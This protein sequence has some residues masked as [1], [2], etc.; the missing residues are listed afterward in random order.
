MFAV[1]GGRAKEYPAEYEPKDIIVWNEDKAECQSY[2]V[3]EFSERFEADSIC[4]MPIDSNGERRVWRWSDREKILQAAS[5]GEFVLK[6]SNGNYS[7]QLKDRIKEGRKPKTIWNDSKYDASSH[8][9]NLLKSIMGGRKSFGYP[10]S[11]Y[12][13]KDALHCLVGNDKEAVIVDC[14]GGSAT[15]AHAV[16]NLNREDSGRRKFLIAEM[17]AYFDLV[18]KPRCLKAA[19]SSDWSD[20][21]PQSAD[22]L[23]YVLKCIRVE[24]YEDALNNLS[25]QNVMQ[26]TGDAEFRQEYM[27]RYWLDFETKG[28]PSLLNIEQF[29]DPT[30]YKLNVKKPGTDE[31]VE[32]SVD[33]IE[34]FNWLIGLHVEHIDQW[35]G[36]DAAF[37]REEDAE[38]PGDTSTRLMI[39]GSL[40]ETEE[41]AWRFRK[42]E[43][44]TLRTPGD[45]SDRERALVVWRKLTGDLEQDNLMLDEWFR[46]YRL[47]AQDTEFDVIYVNGSNNLPNLRQEEET[48]KVR[49]IEEAFH[50]AM[51]DVEG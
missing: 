41:G 6:E 49:L 31:Y 37:K 45:Q 38:L 46:K 40:K 27:L 2:S 10:K 23:S 51:W 36:Y 15:T 32:K 33:L 47:S 14:F 4:V 44:Y 1:G 42:I 22:S 28:S 18:T 16:F 39:D 29:S 17:G 5:I 25:L 24:T 43:G 19:Y 11:L 12:A 3:Q 34:T 21:K 8:G 20:G 26:A 35:R 48:W 9:T 30:R 13:T 50:Q 7:V